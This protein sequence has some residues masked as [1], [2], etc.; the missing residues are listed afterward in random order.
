[1]LQV[2]VLCRLQHQNVIRFVGVCHLPLCFALELAPM[3]SLQTILE[4]LQIEREGKYRG[5]PTSNMYVGSIIGKVITH[6]I[7]LEV[8]NCTAI[9]NELNIL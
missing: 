9:R 6:Q 7:A 5:V 2:A 8:T 4:K 3:G 1:M